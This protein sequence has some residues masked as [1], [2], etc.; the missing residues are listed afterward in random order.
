MPPIKIMGILYCLLNMGDTMK[1]LFV[2]C[3]TGIAGDMLGAALIDLFPDKKSII[4]ALNEIGI[5][6]IIFSTEKSKKPWYFW[7]SSLSE[8]QWGRRMSGR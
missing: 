6:G 5:P 4:S 2:D 7:N 1:K 3:S 8:I